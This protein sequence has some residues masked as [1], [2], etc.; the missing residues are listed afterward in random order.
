M[1]GASKDRVIG[2]FFRGS[3]CSLGYGIIDGI[4]WMAKES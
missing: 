1:E 4:L 3:V 2:A